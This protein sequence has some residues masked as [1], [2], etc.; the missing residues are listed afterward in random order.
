MASFCF[1]KNYLEYHDWQQLAAEK[2]APGEENLVQSKNDLHREQFLERFFS[3]SLFARTS[4]RSSKSLS[5]D[6]D[7][8]DDM[9]SVWLAGRSC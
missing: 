1:R 7:D 8:D 2:K 4:V 3:L 6:D 5:D 9:P